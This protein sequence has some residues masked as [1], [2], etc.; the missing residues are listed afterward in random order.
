MSKDTGSRGHQKR[1]APLKPA[2]NRQ[3]GQVETGQQPRRPGIQPVNLDDLIGQ[4]RRFIMRA[5]SVEIKLLQEAVNAEP[6][7][8][9]RADIMKVVAAIKADGQA[10]MEVMTVKMLRGA[11]AEFYQPEPEPDEKQ[12]DEPPTINI[13]PEPADAEAEARAAAELEAERERLKK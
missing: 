12:P 13:T 6:D 1:P 10:Q 5:V 11:G 9:R 7:I 3:P 2:N 8:L 4:A